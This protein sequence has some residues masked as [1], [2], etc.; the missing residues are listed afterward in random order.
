[1]LPAG[2]GE[3]VQSNIQAAWNGE[4]RVRQHEF[5][6]YVLLLHY[7]PLRD[8]SGTIT[9]VMVVAQDTTELREA[10]TA[11]RESE[12]RYRLI[13][14]NSTDMITVQLASGVITYV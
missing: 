13:A 7:V 8:D 10:D 3:S 2:V 6:E 9:E 5:A 11:L 12:A 14:D 1:M 4:V